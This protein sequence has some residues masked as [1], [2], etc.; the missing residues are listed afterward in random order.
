MVQITSAQGTKKYGLII[1][2][3]NVVKFSR[4]PIENT[5]KGGVTALIHTIV[6]PWENEFETAMVGLA[7]ALD[8]LDDLT[9][10]SM[11]VRSAKDIEQA[12]E[13][14][15][16]GIIMGTQN[17]SLVEN[18]LSL[19]VILQR[20]GF[21]VV[22]L[23][24]NNSNRLGDGVTVPEDKGLTELGREWVHEMNRL[25]MV[26]DLSHC[27]YRTSTDAIAESDTPVIFSH[28]NASAL[29]NCSRNKPDNL[30]RS[31]AETGGVIG[32]T[33]WS[34]LL[35]LSGPSTLDDYLDQFEYIANLA[36]I[37]HVSFASDTAEGVVTREEWTKT[38]K[39]DGVFYNPSF[40]GKLDW[41]SYDTR[42]PKGYESI[43]DTTHVWDGLVERGFSEDEVEKIMGRNL[44]RVF[45]EIWGV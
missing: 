35:K 3:T 32:V 14:K 28:S 20:L 4:D 9:D 12:Q 26:I 40:T 36:G 45:R 38:H 43:I 21:R 37:D 23:T 13:S 39:P 31:I 25:H 19:L 18:D 22:Q 2:G 34:P 16:V 1:D 41:F 8:H 10:I 15:R 17:S 5:R 30:I 44:L 7:Q 33:S 24:Y 29:C 42:R 11:I 6:E 27:G